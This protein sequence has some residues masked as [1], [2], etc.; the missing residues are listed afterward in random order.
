MIPMN[1]V[2]YQADPETAYMLLAKLAG[3][4]G[5]SAISLAYVL[6]VGRREA[7]LRFATG[8]VAGVIFGASAGVKLADYLDISQQI[9]R[10]EMTMSGAAATS[11]AAWWALGVI[12]RLA[13]RYGATVS[14]TA[15]D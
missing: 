4:I 14:T 13:A 3:A 7:A 12:A 1:N 9:S 6:P 8:L 10:F 2:S 15:K 5:G 11:L